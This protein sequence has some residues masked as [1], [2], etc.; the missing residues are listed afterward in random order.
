MER[1]DQRFE[2]VDSDVIVVAVKKA[3]EAAY[4]LGRKSRIVWNGIMVVAAPSK[5]NRN[6]IDIVTCWEASKDQ[7][8]RG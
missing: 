8:Q 2:L 7:L 4:M 6:A 5:R 1:V 3:A